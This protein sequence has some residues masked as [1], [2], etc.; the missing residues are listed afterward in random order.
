[1]PVSIDDIVPIGQVRARFTEVAEQARAGADKLITRNGEA[2]VAVIDARRL[3]HLQR[4]EREHVHLQLLDA[5]SAG[6]DAIDR[7]DVVDEET[8]WAR[9]GR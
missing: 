3:E 4:L 6:L 7:G 5:A 2:F 1:M 9:L 8:M